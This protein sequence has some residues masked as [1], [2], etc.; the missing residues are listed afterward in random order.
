MLSLHQK[1]LKVKITIFSELVLHGVGEVSS[2]L[3]L[4]ITLDEDTEYALQLQGLSLQHSG[5][6]VHF[7]V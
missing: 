3:P 1:H 7:Y 2:I 6:Y 4:S 5:Y